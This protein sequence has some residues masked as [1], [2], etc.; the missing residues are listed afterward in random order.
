MEHSRKSIQETGIQKSSTVSRKSARCGNIGDEDGRDVPLSKMCLSGWLASAGDWRTTKMA[1]PRLTWTTPISPSEW[2]CF[3][4]TMIHK[5]PRPLLISLPL[6][7]V[8][9]WLK[10]KHPVKQRRVENEDPTPPIIPQT[11]PPTLLGQVEKLKCPVIC[12][13]SFRCFF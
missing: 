5:I 2:T 4:I 10:T 1:L 13:I 6:L 11:F 3:L 8:L 7:S 9:F 12:S